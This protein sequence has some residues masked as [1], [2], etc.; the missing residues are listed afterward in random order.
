MRGII[1]IPQNLRGRLGKFYCDTT[2]PPPPPPAIVA[3]G[4]EPP[5]KTLLIE[6]GAGTAYQPS[7]EWSYQGLINEI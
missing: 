7:F 4:L 3:F 5:R 1:K 6:S 2:I